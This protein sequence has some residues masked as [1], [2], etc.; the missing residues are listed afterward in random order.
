MHSLMPSTPSTRQ[1]CKG[2]DKGSSRARSKY[3]AAYTVWQ[4]SKAKKGKGVG[5][6]KAKAK[7]EPAVGGL[8]KGKGQSLKHRLPFASSALQVDADGT[9]R[10]R[11]GVCVSLA[12]LFASLGHDFTA[13]EIYKY[14][15]LCTPFATKKP[16]GWSA[17][18]RQ[19]AR[20]EQYKATGR[21]PRGR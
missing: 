7:D 16:H 4:G 2:L 17:P 6:G 9:W 1:L 3:A 8:G 13:V 14:Y 21:L 20:H 11:Q 12:Q 18:V 19:Q 10:Y 5:K 15:N